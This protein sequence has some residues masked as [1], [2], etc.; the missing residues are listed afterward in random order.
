MREKYWESERD[1]REEERRRG[2]SKKVV[3]HKQKGVMVL[4]CS[5]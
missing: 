5:K 3:S 4:F 2:T 1:L